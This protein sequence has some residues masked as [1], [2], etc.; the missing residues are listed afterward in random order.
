VRYLKRK[1]DGQKLV[2]P[3]SKMDLYGHGKIVKLEEK[4]ENG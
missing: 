2:N 3:H 4:Y 1:I